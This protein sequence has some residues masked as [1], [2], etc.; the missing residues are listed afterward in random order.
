M[1]LSKIWVTLSVSLSTLPCGIVRDVSL[2]LIRPLAIRIGSTISNGAPVG[3]TALNCPAATRSRDTGNAI[4][5]AA[6]SLRSRACSAVKPLKIPAGKKVRVLLLRLRLCSEVN[7]L[8][9]ASGS[10]LSGLLSKSSPSNEANPP[11]IPIGRKVKLLLFRS[12]RWSEV[13]SLK[14]PT[15]RKVSWLLFRLSTSSDVSP[16]KSPAFKETIVLSERSSEVMADRCASVTSSGEVTPA[17]ATIASRT[18][19]VRSLSRFIP[20]ASIS[21]SGS[22]SDFTKAYPL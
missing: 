19:G 6:L 14:T 8:K 17:A 16:S 15:G 7:P 20:C 13:S 3:A 10:A 18:C 4:G 2:P 5:A 22:S 9:T 12:K 11:N 1:R 21:T